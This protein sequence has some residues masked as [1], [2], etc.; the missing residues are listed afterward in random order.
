VLIRVV[1]GRA[2]LVIHVNNCLVE[3][4]EDRHGRVGKCWARRN[5]DEAL[6]VRGG[7]QIDRVLW[8]AM[9][10]HGLSIPKPDRSAFAICGRSMCRSLSG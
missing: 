4:L 10:E 7:C 8:D 5:I 2:S 6:R 1:P 9:R 3:L